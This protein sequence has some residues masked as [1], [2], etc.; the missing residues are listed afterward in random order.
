VRAIAVYL[1]EG[2]DRPANAPD[3][4][5]GAAALA[6]GQ[7]VYLANC[8]ACHQD[9]GRGIPGAVANLADN[10]ALLGAQPRDAIVAVLQGLQ[11]TGGYGQMPSFAGLLGDQAVSDVVN[12]I[13]SAWAQKAATDA[14]PATVAGL[15]G[16]ANVGAAGTEAARAFDCPP[17]GSPIE[18]AALASP[19]QANFLASDDGAF[20]TQRVVEMIARMRSQQPGLSDASLT[21]AM[22]AA[23]CP[24]VANRADLSLDAKRALLAR[25]NTL[26]Q[27]QVAAARV[28]PNTGVV[29]TVPL[30]ATTAQML[31]NAAAAH[32]Q[33]PDVYMAELLGKAAQ[34]AK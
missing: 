10:A 7:Q 4:A 13:R 15:R 29:A 20:L 34:T 2:P 11:G 16:L 9:N 17:V 19:A 14:T 6:R 1:K 24:A 8:A 25:L 3:A 33:S 27:Q 31:Y 30:G 23:F 22:N 5:A 21:N 26:V 28:A 18:P 32:N 12:Y